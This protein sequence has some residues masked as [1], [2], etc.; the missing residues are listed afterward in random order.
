MIK[1]LLA[2][3]ERKIREGIRDIIDWTKLGIQLLE[4]APNGSIA[5]KLAYKYKPNIVIT[6]LK[7]PGLQGLELINK[8][9]MNPNIPNPIFIILTGYN[10]FEFAQ[11]A[12]RYG[13]RHYLLKPTSEEEI[14]LVLQDAIWLIR[15]DSSPLYI[16]RNKLN[17][18]VPIL[19]TLDYLEDNLAQP[20]ISLKN[21]AQNVVFM[22]EEY[23]G[24]LFQKETGMKFT[25]YLQE[26][27]I[28]LAK[29]LLKKNMSMSALQAASKVGYGNNPQYFSTVFK[30]ET[31]MTPKQYQNTDHLKK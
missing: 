3:D 22:N 25:K 31:G 27:R 15:H 12:M 8:I 29:K 13:V 28:S 10:D 24:K 2:D 30:S 19:K 26:K 5:Y 11:Q 23:L 6:D 17:Y 9:Q 16:P 20:G 21:I 14:S 7:M 18:S 4:L 1:V